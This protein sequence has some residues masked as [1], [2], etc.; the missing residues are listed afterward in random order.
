[1]MLLGRTYDGVQAAE[2][3]LANFCYDDATFDS[4]VASLAGELLAG[5]WF[6]HRANKRLLR[7]T[8]GLPLDAGL[9]HEVFRNAGK[10]PDMQQRIAAF[11]KK[12]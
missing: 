1:M 12:A 5:S 10:G 2:I 8:D 9:A 7:E 3:G 6:S 11:G 4:E